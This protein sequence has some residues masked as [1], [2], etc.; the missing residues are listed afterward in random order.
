MLGMNK[1]TTSLEKSAVVSSFQPRLAADCRLLIL[2]TA[3]SEKSL[4]LQQVYAHPQ[5]LFWP[6]MGELFSAGPELDYVERI[7]RLQRA[8]IGIWDVLKH[9]QRPGSLDSSIVRGSEVPN[10]VPELLVTHLQIDTV[11]FNGS[12]AFELFKRH[13]LPRFDAQQSARVQWLP[14]PSTSPAN[15]SI[16]R[17][18]KLRRWS[19]LKYLLGG[20]HAD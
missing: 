11:A 12:K 8:G 19:A 17:A 2:G 6:F 3:P 1:K 14:L 4:A 16:G 15:A 9:C 13:I 5:N 10:A 18:E 7:A 20:A